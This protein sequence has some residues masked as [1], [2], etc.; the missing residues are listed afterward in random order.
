MTRAAEAA[1]LAPL[2][3]TGTKGGAVVSTAKGK[4]KVV[5]LLQMAPSGITADESRVTYC[6]AKGHC[7]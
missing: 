3:E 1:Q 7:V 4:D 6:I 5:T 2:S